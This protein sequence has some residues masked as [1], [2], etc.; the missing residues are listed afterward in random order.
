M[1]RVQREAEEMKKLYIAHTYGRRHLLPEKQLERNALK[2]IVWG[3]KCIEKGWN[4]F[5]PN[6]FH[7][8]HSGWEFSPDEDFWLNLV[9]EWINFCDALFVA[10]MPIWHNSGVEYEIELAKKL[11]IPVYYFFQDIPSV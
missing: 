8:V 2:S 3:R 10:E 1:G 6:L 11:N 4:P 5:I 9:S 7:F